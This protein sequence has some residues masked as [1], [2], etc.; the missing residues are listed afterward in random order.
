MLSFKSCLGHE[1]PHSNKTEP[2]T[3]RKLGEQSGKVNTEFLQI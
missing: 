3:A 1:S 2:K